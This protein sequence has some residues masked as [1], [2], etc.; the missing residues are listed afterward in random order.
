MASRSAAAGLLLLGVA[1][2]AS[3]QSGAA[4]LA[5][6]DRDW[7]LLHTASAMRG[8][9]RVTADPRVAAD[10]WLG[11]GRIHA[12]RGWQAEGA[13]PGWHEEVDQRPLALAAYR[14]AA[15]LRPDW[16]APHVA[17]G[18]ALLLDGRPAE[19]AAAFARA[20]AL[21]PGDPAAT[22]G[23]QRASGATPADPE[24]EA[25]AA[26]D[27]AM[28]AGPPEAAVA[29]VRAFERRWPSS[30]RLIEAGDRLLAIYLAWDAAPSADVLAAVEARLDLR[31]DPMAYAAAINVLL[32]RRVALDR[33]GALAEA[34]TAAGERFVT[35]NE[36]SYKLGG[37]VR[38][39]RDRTRAGFADQTGWAAFLQGDRSAADR[40]LEEAARLA[41]GTDVV[42]Q[43]HRAELAR[44]RG[45]AELARERYYEALSL[46]SPPPLA[47][48]RAAAE[49]ALAGLYAA[50]GVTA[51]D[52]E[53][54]IGRELERR[55]DE[56][57]R[58][59]LSSALGK[60]LPAL[61]T[62]DMAGTPVAL[63][64]AKGQVILLNFFAAW[65]GACRQEIPFIQQAYERYKDDPA[66]RFVLVSLD[67]DPRR[68][69]RYV[70]E[71]QFQMPV[72][73]M[74]RDQAA[75]A[76]DVQDTPWTFYVDAGGTIRYE[77]RGLEPHGDAVARISW[78]IDRLKADA[79]G[80]R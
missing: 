39:F 75:A 46:D 6:A 38:A 42:N 59:L 32:A 33:V 57:R 2:A 60:A 72:L 1:A 69:E 37:K 70:A 54:N 22:R 58:A 63:P 16:A 17:L 3:A 43:F 4:T 5:Q 56:R 51:A 8:Y 52:T 65:C 20:L 67:D 11:L 80:A 49:A 45:D 27:A 34:G 36:P 71:R 64:A 50:E 44:A 55:R 30:P 68:L 28:K 14:R 10:G 9:E 76:L 73:R 77:V 62:T 18:E 19:A 31:P 78:Y 40:H 48:L 25:L 35:E 13:F 23:A 79:A 61:P 66:V 53:V 12:F 47:R 74:T 7:R 29:A 15:D 21:A 41:N 24:R 26:I